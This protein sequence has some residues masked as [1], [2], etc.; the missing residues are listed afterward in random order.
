MSKGMVAKAAVAIDAPKEKVWEALV[1]PALIKQYM[2]GTDTACEWK[3][4][5]AI[6]WSGVWQ[7]KAYVDKGVIL[8]I[9]RE[10]VLRYTYFSPLAGQADVPENYHTVTVKVA[11]TEN[12]T[13]LSLLQDNNRTQQEMEHSQQNWNMV[14]DS[15]KKLLEK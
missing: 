14:F 5:S 4:G 2:F 6:T 8:K 11:N 12:G 3:K 15:I 9:E 10:R 13:L 7:G 1:N